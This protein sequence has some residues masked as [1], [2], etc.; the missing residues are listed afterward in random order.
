M[1][2]P[3]DAN[4][5]VVFGSYDPDK[6]RFTLNTHGD[7]A[8]F[9]FDEMLDTITHEIGHKK[10]AQ[11]VKDF[12]SGKLSPSDPQYQEAAALAD[13]EWF[14][15]EHPKEFAKVYVTSP[16]ESHA[17]AMGAEMKGLMGRAFGKDPNQKLEVSGP[18]TGAN[19]EAPKTGT[20]AHPA[21]GH[22][23]DHDH[24]HDE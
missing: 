17:R 10:Q 7:A 19:L 16:K 11:L 8:Q 22:D 3:S 14:K 9:G 2:T 6:D 20:G 13:H 21:G 23:H 18:G 24:D 1:S 4:G 15:K 5:Q 12:K